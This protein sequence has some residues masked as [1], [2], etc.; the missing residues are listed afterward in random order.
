MS[1]RQKIIAQYTAEAEYV[2]ACEACMGEQS[3]KNML[4][5][6]FPEMIVHFTLGIDNQVAFLLATI[7]IVVGVLEISSS[8]DTM[9]VI[10]LP[11]R[12]KRYVKSIHMET[13]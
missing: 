10:E 12:P 3:L 5:E 8:V 11:R 2:A 9:C 6:V 7:I 1:R 4:S 13:R